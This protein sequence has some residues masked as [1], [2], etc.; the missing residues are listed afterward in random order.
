MR[1]I[2]PLAVDFVARWEG[3]SLTTYRDVA[4]V[5]TV[6]YGHT[7]S[8]VVE[9]GA[10]TRTAARRL[11]KDDLALAGARLE[12]RIG[13]GVVAAL[14]EAQYAALLSFVFNLGANAN[15]TIWR[16]L[17]ARR[18]D[19]VP[20]QLMRFVNAGGR[21]V[22]GLVNRRAAEAALWHSAETAGVEEAQAITP[23]SS[24]TRAIPT[25]PT[26]ADSKPLAQSKS[27]VATAATGVASA[28]VA[29]G[30]VS[31]AVSP[32]A[33]QSEIVARV[34]SALA[35]AAAALAVAAV[36]FV[37]LKRRGGRV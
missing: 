37:W 14:T 26:P 5:L 21:V 32:Y 7:G 18:F 6:G 15:W 36:V 27:F 1:P 10:I 23:P 31:R 12:T 34:V 9:G 24:V 3:C 4:G 33:G 13:K 25:P 22:K 30:E 17:K 29:V 8:D 35:L 2:H 20:P 11:L 19:E 28:A 16:V